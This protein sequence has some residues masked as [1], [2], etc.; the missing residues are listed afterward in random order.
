MENFKMKKLFK[1]IVSFA[2]AVAMTLSVSVTAKAATAGID[3]VKITSSY[4]LVSSCCFWYFFYI[5]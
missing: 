4:R 5:Y 3:I 1:R 2:M